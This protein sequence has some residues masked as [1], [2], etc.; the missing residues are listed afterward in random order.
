MC[1][2]LEVVDG[3][4]I[5]ESHGRNGEVTLRLRYADGRMT[6]C[7]GSSHVLRVSGAYCNSREMVKKLARVIESHVTAA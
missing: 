7:F 2:M 1:R 5:T 6:V 3:I 4:T